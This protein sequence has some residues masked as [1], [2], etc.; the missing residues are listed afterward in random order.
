VGASSQPRTSAKEVD[1]VQKQLITGPNFK[2]GL[3]GRVWSPG[4]KVGPWVFLSGVTAMD[5]KT[6]KTVGASGA[7]STTPAKIH[8][9]A[10]WRQVLGNIKELIES[11]GG[12]MADIVMA[13]VFVTD[14][15]YYAHYQHIREEFFTPPYPVCTA[16]AVRDLV[17]P[18]WILE[19]EAIAYIER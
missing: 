2:Q 6:M 5:Y 8:P 12:T 16:V 11:A 3:G 14:M 1:M 10:Q 4:L 9:E 7:T 15:Q 19:I 18:D 13:N 17:H